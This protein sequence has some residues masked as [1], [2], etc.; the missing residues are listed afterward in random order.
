M[1]NINC[2]TPSSSIMNKID[3]KAKFLR[4]TFKVS[5]FSSISKKEKTEKKTVQEIGQQVEK[6]QEKTKKEERM[7]LTRVIYHG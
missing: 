5:S 3:S 6:E 4:N 7:I 2:W 1:Y